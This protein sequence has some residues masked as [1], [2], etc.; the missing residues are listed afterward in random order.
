[1]K[2]NIQYTH[3]HTHTMANGEFFLDGTASL[4][5]AGHQQCVFHLKPLLDSHAISTYYVSHGL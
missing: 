4:L 2:Q 5:S 1:M 3:D